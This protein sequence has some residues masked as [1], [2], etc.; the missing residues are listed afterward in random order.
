MLDIN[1]NIHCPDL[2]LAADKLA[3]AINR[4]AGSVEAASAI[5]RS[6]APAAAMPVT[7]KTVQAS[8]PVTPTFTPA[9]PVVPAVPIQTFTP[10][11]NQAAPM[12]AAAPTPTVA[13]SIPA[14][15]TTVPT[16]THEQVG[17]AGADLVA[18]NPAMMPTLMGLL[19]R[20]GVQLVTDLK[21]E[22][23]GPFAL[24]LRGLGARI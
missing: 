21:P 19:H 16:Y 24:E 14:P 10:P 17:R 20:Y 9:V 13:P 6:E 22:Q 15:A 4:R 5:L 23:L 2:A 18:A 11:V 8:A 12:P 7:P 1:V 3:A